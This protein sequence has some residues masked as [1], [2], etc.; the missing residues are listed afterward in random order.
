MAFDAFDSLVANARFYRGLTPDRRIRARDLRPA[1]RSWGIPRIGYSAT[2]PSGPKRAPSSSVTGVRTSHHRTRPGRS[3]HMHRRARSSPS[4]FLR[5]GRQVRAGRPLRIEVAQ[6]SLHGCIVARGIRPARQMRPAHEDDV[7]VRHVGLAV[8]PHP[9]EFVAR[10]QFGDAGPV[11]AHLARCADRRR[12]LLQGE[13]RGR[14][15]G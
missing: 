7:E 8:V 4:P 10:D 6:E 13:T 14:P 9:T 1:A 11:L 15:E 12:S 2:R 3:T 5:E